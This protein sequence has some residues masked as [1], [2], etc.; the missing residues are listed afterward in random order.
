M[1][2]H[3]IDLSLHSESSF[4]EQIAVLY[5]AGD[6]DDGKIKFIRSFLP[7]GQFASVGFDCDNPGTDTNSGWKN[8]DDLIEKQNVRG[9]FHT[10]PKGILDFSETDFITM[11]G[12]AKANGRRP[13]FHGVQSLGSQSHFIC[14]R[15]LRSQV[16]FYDLGWF[17]LD[18]NDPIIILPGPPF[19]EEISIASDKVLIFPFDENI[20]L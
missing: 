17:D 1:L 19:V 8:V 4:K 6:T 7:A 13:L 14:A 15:M 10:H 18:V 11:I 9:I 5:V 12:L 16:H 20:R 2:I 3:P